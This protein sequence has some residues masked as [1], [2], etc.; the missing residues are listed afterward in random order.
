M[1][2]TD[3]DMERALKGEDD[4]RS[5]RQHKVIQIATMV[6]PGRLP[7]FLALRDDG[8]IFFKEL[9]IGW[10]RMQDVPKD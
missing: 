2:E 8:S 10:Q 9:G 4:D 1:S 3:I 5:H 6:A 7:L